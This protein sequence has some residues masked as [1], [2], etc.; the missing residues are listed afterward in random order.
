M[1]G[2]FIYK[3]ALMGGKEL[4]NVFI[5]DLASFFLVIGDEFLEDS[6]QDFFNFSGQHFS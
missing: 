6:D 2:S 4:F 5:G 3:F 1:N